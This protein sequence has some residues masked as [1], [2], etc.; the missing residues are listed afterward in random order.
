MENYDKERVSKNLKAAIIWLLEARN[1]IA[2]NDVKKAIAEMKIAKEAIREGQ[3]FA[4]NI[5][6]DEEISKLKQ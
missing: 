3:Q 5:L 6:F 2:E 4:T 1:S